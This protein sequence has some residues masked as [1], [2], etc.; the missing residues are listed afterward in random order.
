MSASIP[1]E[2][3]ARPAATET[4]R[5]PEIARAALLALTAYC[6]SLGLTATIVPRVFFDDFPFLAH[7]VERLPPYNEHLVTDVGGLYLGFAVVLGLAA[8]RPRR[9]LVIAACAGFLTM[10]VPHLAF[11]ATHLSGFG[12]G[13]AIAEL[14]A[15]ASLL[16]PPVVAIW[17]SASAEPAGATAAATQR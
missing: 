17:A 5:R 9:D 10:A 16:I 3:S 7:W 15:L 1:A 6:L 11:H 8:W 14:G 13:G 12:T 4:M 2:P